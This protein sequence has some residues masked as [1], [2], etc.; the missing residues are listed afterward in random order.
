MDE[1]VTPSLKSF[2]IT[3]CPTER[4]ADC[5]IWYTN[6]IVGI[7]VVCDCQSCGH[8]KKKN[9]EEVTQTN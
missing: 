1:S 2:S 8:N 5:V 4:C 7:T 6:R 3:R 9:D